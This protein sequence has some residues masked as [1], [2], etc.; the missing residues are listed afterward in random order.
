M[1]RRTPMARRLFT[2]RQLV[3]L[4]S[5]GALLGGARFGQR[6][7]SRSAE[8]SGPLSEEACALIARAWVGLNPARVLDVHVH[9]LGTGTGGTGCFVGP[10][11]RSLLRPIDYFKFSLYEQASGISDSA[12]SDAQYIDRLAGLIKSQSPHGRALL[13][14]FD[15]L[16]D[17]EGNPDIQSSEFSL[18]TPMS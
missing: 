9:V 13:F 2:R 18:P 6:R 10:R 8:P 11:M 4:A 16:H 14:A 17:A 15:K 5:G 7:L 12:H 1:V 3:F